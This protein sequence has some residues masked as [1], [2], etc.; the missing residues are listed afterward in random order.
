MN[1]YEF[2]VVNEYG[3]INK[4]TISS[5]IK[6]TEEAAT[7]NLGKDWQNSGC[8]ICQ[9]IPFLVKG[10]AAGYWYNNDRKYLV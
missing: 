4:E 5:T 6:A 8:C 7:L 10:R 9:I 1:M 2:A 3:A